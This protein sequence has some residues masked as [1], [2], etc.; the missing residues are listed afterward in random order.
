MFLPKGAFNTS[1]PSGSV[2]GGHGLKETKQ[3]PPQVLL[4]GL[5]GPKKV[6]Q[7][8]RS[9]LINKTPFRQ[10]MIQ[11][12]FHWGLPGHLGVQPGICSCMSSSAWAAGKLRLVHCAR[13]LRHELVRR[14]LYRLRGILVEVVATMLCE[15]LPT[16]ILGDNVAQLRQGNRF[17][18]RQANFWSGQSNW[19]P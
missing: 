14:D 2:Y 17:T 11:W 10:A 18:I 19:I 4:I 9:T 6:V 1:F 7:S 16:T 5:R 3:I 8:P 12:L 15:A 13:K